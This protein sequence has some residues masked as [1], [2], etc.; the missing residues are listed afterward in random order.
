VGYLGELG[1][2]LGQLGAL[3]SGAR[4]HVGG[5]AAGL[6]WLAELSAHGGGGSNRGLGA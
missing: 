4:A 2:P 1:L 3:A 6:G 5:V